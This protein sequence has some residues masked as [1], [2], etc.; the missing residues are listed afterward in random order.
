MK[1]V[2]T[3][4][5][6]FPINAAAV[7]AQQHYQYNPPSYFSSQGTS[8]VIVPPTV[9][10]PAATP[11]KNESKKSCR[12]SEIDLFLFSIRRTKGDCTQ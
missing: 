1:I 6:L 12:E 7:Q 5:A 2:L 4:L 11:M 8:P 10:A 3:I 9:I